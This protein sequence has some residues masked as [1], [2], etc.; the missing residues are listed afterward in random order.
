MGSLLEIVGA[1]ALIGVFSYGVVSILRAVTKK[2][3]DE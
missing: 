2:E 3:K 1:I